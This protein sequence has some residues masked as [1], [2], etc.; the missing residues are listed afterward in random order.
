M[1][2]HPQAQA[3]IDA[4]A[5]AS[6]PPLH[7]L[8]GVEARA[9]SAARPVAPISTGLDVRSEDLAIPGPGGNSLPVRIYTPSR[10]NE[11]AEGLPVLVWFHG[12]GWVTGSLDSNDSTCA[13]LAHHAGAVVVSVDYRLA[14]EHRYPAAA[15]DAYAGTLWVAEHASEIGGNGDFVAV[16]GTS[17]GGN[18]A[19]AVT[20]MVRDREGPRLIHQMLVYPVTD[21][22]FTCESYETNGEGN[23]LTTASMEWY[24]QQ[25]LGPDGDRTSPYAVVMRAEDFAGLPRAHVITAEFDP[26]C[27]EGEE[28]GR[29]LEECGVFT[30]MTRYPGMIHGF[31]NMTAAIDDATKAIRE[32]AAQLRISVSIAAAK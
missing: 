20:Q 26:L 8:T 23:G 32:D 22:D 25:Y 2:L 11:A 3:V 24:W 10:A 27:G 14:P 12:G 5:R 17:A 16:G 13:L 15:E 6:L 9:R 7:T 4:E 1:P 31:F 29:R 28:Y 18:L 19:A 30:V 21:C